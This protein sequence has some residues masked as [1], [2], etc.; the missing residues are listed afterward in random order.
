MRKNVILVLCLAFLA[1]GVLFAVL[2][3]TALSERVHRLEQNQAVTTPPSDSGPQ[4]RIA[5][6]DGS[7][8]KVLRI[9]DGDTVEIETMHGSL[10]LRVIGIDTP[11]TLHPL[12]PVEP[13]GPEA[14]QRAK[15]LLS[16]KTVKIHYDSDPKHETWGKY[17]RLLAYLELPGGRDFGLVMI[18][19]G[20]AKA[21]PKYPFSRVAAYL[22]AE[23]KAKAGNV[24]LW[25]SRQPTTVPT[26]QPQIPH[27][28]ASDARSRGI[29]FPISITIRP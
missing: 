8:H 24:G 9:I 23:Q 4:K 25:Q 17:G 1:A 29:K 15:E 7:L 5:P 3:I 20:L 27:P 22:A 6:P 18:N 26:T 11:E 19:E 28:R 12:K 2:R 14:S 21:Y 10:R 16:D 13:F